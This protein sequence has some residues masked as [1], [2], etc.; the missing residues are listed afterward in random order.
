[1]KLAVEHVL[2]ANEGGKF[3]LEKQVGFRLGGGLCDGLTA[4]F[5]DVVLKARGPELGEYEAI[6][7][8]L[9]HGADQRVKIVVLN[10]HVEEV[11]GA[12][13]ATAVLVAGLGVGCVGRLGQNLPGD[14]HIFDPAILSDEFGLEAVGFRIGRSGRDGGGL[15]GADESSGLVALGAAGA[16][17]AAGETLDEKLLDGGS[18]SE[19]G[20]EAGEDGVEVGGFFGGARGGEE[21]GAGEEAMTEAVG[22]GSGLAFG[23]AGAGGFFGVGAVGGEGSGGHCLGHETLPF[24]AFAQKENMRGARRFGWKTESRKR[25][26]IAGRAGSEPQITPMDADS[27]GSNSSEL[28]G[29]DHCDLIYR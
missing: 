2:V 11:G 29:S 26:E 19:V 17:S 21:G 25:N 8:S 5:G 24:R 6:V 1:M 27:S 4:G 3:F 13:D 20:V 10:I 22:G 28:K 7:K 9:F 14:E 23:G 16:P 12:A 15:G 18:G